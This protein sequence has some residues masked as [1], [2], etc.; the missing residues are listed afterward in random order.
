MGNIASALEP[1]SLNLMQAAASLLWIIVIA[2]KLVSLLPTLDPYNLFSV[3][4]A[5]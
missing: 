3:Y 5:K 2:S 1:L 4:L